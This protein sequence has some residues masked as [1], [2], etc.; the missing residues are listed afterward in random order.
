MSGVQ[1]ADNASDTGEALVHLHQC[2]ASSTTGKYLMDHTRRY[3]RLCDLEIIYVAGP[4]LNTDPEKVTCE[5]CQNQLTQML[6]HSL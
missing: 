2:S 3:T 1:Q 4:K 6:V 5:E